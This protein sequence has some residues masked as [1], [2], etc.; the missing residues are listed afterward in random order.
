MP[1]VRL[2]SRTYYNGRISSK[3]AQIIDNIHALWIAHVFLFYLMYKINVFWGQQ[4]DKS[5][6][7]L[8]WI[9]RIVAVVGCGLFVLWPFW[10]MAVARCGRS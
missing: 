8:M 6:L 3:F 9:M 2:V 7:W 10:Y 5:V 4:D 1:K